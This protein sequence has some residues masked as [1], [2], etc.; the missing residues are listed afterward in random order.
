[1]LS[2]Q[3]AKTATGD[4]I[5]VIVLTVIVAGL[6]VKLSYYRHRI[7]DRFQGRSRDKTYDKEEGGS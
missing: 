2:A 1:V 5:D 7:V 3:G 4:Y 6:A